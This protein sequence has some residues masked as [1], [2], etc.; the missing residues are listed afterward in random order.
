MVGGEQPRWRGDG[1]ELFFVA[2]DGKMMAVPVKAAAP[3]GRGG[4]PF[5]E[6]G[7]PL[8]LF[9]AHMTQV[10]LLF[11]YDVTADGKRFLI[12]TTGATTSATS[13]PLTMVVNWN[14]GLKR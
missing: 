9:D 6:A 1:K 4:K 10:G 13:P 2:G 8:A 11:Q 12:D 7:A 5:F 3:S 14:A